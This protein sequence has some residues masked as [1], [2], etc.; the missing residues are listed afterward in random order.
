MPG[1]LS[2]FSAGSQDPRPE[3]LAGVLC[4]PGQIV[5]RG[6]AAR[7]SVVL[8][9][10]WRVRA[11]VEEFARRGLDGDVVTA[12]PADGWLAVD[13]T[14][15]SVR[16]PFASPLMGLGLEWG[17]SG[18]GKVPP[19]RLVIDGPTLRL[20]YLV[21]GRPWETGYVLGLGEHDDAC[22]EPVGGALAQAGLPAAFVGPRGAGPAYRIIGARRIRRLGE[23]VGDPPEGAP[24]GIWPR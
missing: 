14:A 4:G 8:T 11:L 24:E 12:G 22:W 21:A 1:Q 18:G 15:H 9:E 10:I 19:P 16:T 17:S 3:D 6:S 13:A 2:F 5:R 7:I 20:W 23:L